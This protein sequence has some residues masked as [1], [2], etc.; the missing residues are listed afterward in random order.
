[1]AKAKQANP[2]VVEL[3]PEQLAKLRTLAHPERW[4]DESFN[5]TAIGAFLLREHLIVANPAV[6]TRKAY[7]VTAEGHQTIKA[8]KK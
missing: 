4:V 7:V 2:V 8:A 1:M 5:R 6:G 3:S